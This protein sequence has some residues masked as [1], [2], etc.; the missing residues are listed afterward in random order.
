MRRSSSS[1]VTAGGRFDPIRTTISWAILSASGM[2]RLRSESRASTFGSL[3]TQLRI[4]W[5]ERD[6]Q[7]TRNRRQHDPHEK[8][9]VTDEL[10]ESTAP[11]ARNHH[12]QRHKAGA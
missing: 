7:E 6:G 12:A 8:V 10:L 2:R 1:A 11:H 3:P 9:P 4:E 5:N